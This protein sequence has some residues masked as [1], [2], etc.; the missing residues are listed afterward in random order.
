MFTVGISPLHGET[1]L[2]I[3]CDDMGMCHTVNMA[4]K[5]LIEKGVV[6]STSVMFTCPWYKEAVE[7]LKAHPE[8]GVGIHLVLN[9]E[10]K[11]YKWGPVSGRDTVP[12]L[13]N[14]D[15]YFWESEAKFH[16]AKVN[17]AEVE[18]E[19]R[20][21]IERARAT[22]LRI[23]YVDYHMRTAVSTPQLRDVAEKLAKEYGLAMGKYFGEVE[24]SLWDVPPAKKMG[25]ALKMLDRLEPQ[26]LNLM[27]FHLGYENP[28]MQA[29]ID[30]NNPDD[31][32]RVGEHRYAE[33]K[34]LLSNKFK[35]AIKKRKIKLLTYRDVVTEKGLKS[36]KRP[37][38]ETGY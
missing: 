20:A 19:L 26:K 4:V 1:E 27:V 25:T 7:I 18:K 38:Q 17:M 24:H 36:M 34:V 37:V 5:K 9:S 3:R 32:D 21:Q 35:K 13:V 30:M 10:W 29:L 15:G 8:V 23:D 11:H 14:K 16:A 33:L 6:F 31:P 28:E 2:V 12:S 22:G